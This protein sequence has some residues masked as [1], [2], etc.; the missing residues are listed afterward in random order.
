MAAKT[1]RVEARFPAELKILAERAA[2]ASGFTLT[3]YLANL[4]RADAPKRLQAQSEISLTNHQFD[5]FVAACDASEEPSQ[6]I[7][8]AAR[9]LDAEGF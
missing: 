3:D 6:K 8:Q 5:R 1:E 4:V 2:Q 7:R 9:K